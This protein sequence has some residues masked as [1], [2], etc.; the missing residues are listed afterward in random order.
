[1]EQSN[2]IAKLSTALA[3]AQGEMNPAVKDSNNPFFKSKYADL[4]TIIEAVRPVLSKHEIA[5]VQST[6]LT[7][8]NDFCIVTQ[9]SHSSGEWL[10]GHYLVQCANPNDPQKLGAAV[11]YARRYALKSMI[12]VA[13]EDDDGNG[14]RIENNSK[15]EPPSDNKTFHAKS[16]VW[17]FDKSPKYGHKLE[18]FTEDE[19]KKALAFLGKIQNPKPN[20]LQLSN[21][22]E[23]L[24]GM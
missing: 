13:E 12:G 1:M 8:N 22:I 11:T 7:A 19:L 3:K 5:F 6:A 9:L 24:L 14:N 18:T 21:A 15:K 20:V 16:L 17:P 2:S 4:Q 23:L 10:R